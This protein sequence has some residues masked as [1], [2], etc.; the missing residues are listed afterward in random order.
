MKKA[1]WW[2]AFVGGSVFAIFGSIISAPSMSGIGNVYDW[3]QL[4]NLL[5]RN[6][7]DIFNYA[8]INALFELMTFRKKAGLFVFLRILLG[9]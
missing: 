7:S 4:N 8:R 1:F 5:A 2:D 9:S 3:I 6:I